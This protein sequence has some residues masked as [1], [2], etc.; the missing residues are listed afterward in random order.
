MKSVTYFIATNSKRG[1]FGTLLKEEWK[2]VT[3]KTGI[4][5]GPAIKVTTKVKLHEENQLGFPHAALGLSRR[6]KGY[7]Y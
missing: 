7:D 3:F 6:F 4:L 2:F 5:G 1:I